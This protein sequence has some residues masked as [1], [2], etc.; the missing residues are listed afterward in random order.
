MYIDTQVVCFPSFV[1]SFDVNVFLQ[2][3]NFTTTKNERGEKRKFHQ[4]NEE[5][6]S[7]MVR[8]VNSTIPSLNQPDKKKHKQLQKIPF[9]LVQFWNLF[10]IIFNFCVEKE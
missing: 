7:E 8:L 3:T 4:F 2:D 10:P 1:C 5:R 6:V 9:S